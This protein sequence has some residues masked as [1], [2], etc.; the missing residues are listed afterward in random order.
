MSARPV[1]FATLKTYTTRR[2]TTPAPERP[3]RNAA[4][5]TEKHVD[6]VAA[7][8]RL[9]RESRLTLPEI[10][11]MLK[12]GAPGHSVV[13]SAFEQLERLLV[14]RVGYDEHLVSVKS[15]RKQSKL[16]IEDAEALDRLGIIKIVQ[17]KNGSALSLTDSQLVLIW[18][19]MRAA[20][21]VAELNF[22]PEMLGFYHQAAEFVAGW[23]AKTF[24]ER[25]NGKV[26]VD[27]AAAM[28][29]EALPLMLN[30]FGLLRFKA[31]MSNIDMPKTQPPSTK[32]GR[33]I[34]LKNA[35]PP[36]RTPP[37]VDPQQPD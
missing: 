7:V 31:F 36:L 34:G 27:A 21:F 10:G 6:A 37:H 2:D 17:D 5:Y 15:L 11:A 23:E 20:G 26:E 30:F 18:G 32:A 28:L 19:R 25:T 29:A 1:S 8:Q 3:R 35:T 33:P 4:V 12:G 14:A 9:Q 24:F 22:T 16:A 13:V